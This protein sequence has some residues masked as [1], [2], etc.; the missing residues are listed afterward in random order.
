MSLAGPPQDARLRAASE[1]SAATLAATV[2]ESPVP[3]EPAPRTS[4]ADS[5]TDIAGKRAPSAPPTRG[6]LKSLVVPLVPRSISKGWARGDV[7]GGLASA[8]ASLALAL[9]LGLLAFAPLGPQYAGDRRARRLRVRDLW[10]CHC[11]TAGRC[12]AS[13]QWPA[14]IDEPDPRRIRSQCSRPIRHSRLRQRADPSS[15]SR[16]PAPQS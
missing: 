16:S 1:G 7:T 9:S 2:G 12:G 4:A 6:R 5:A 8:T 14:R 15:S 10:S 3:V 13:R 11:R